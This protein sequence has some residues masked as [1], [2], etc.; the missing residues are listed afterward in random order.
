MTYTATDHDLQCF[1]NLS[2]DLRCIAVVDP[3]ITINER[4]VVESFNLTAEQ[5]FEFRTAEVVGKNIGM[6]MPDP[7][8]GTGIGLI[9]APG[10][11]STFW[12]EFSQ[13]EGMQVAV[14]EE[15]ATQV[16]DIEDSGV[17]FE[18]VQALLSS[19]DA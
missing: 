4:G 9:S 12:V 6:L 17:N 13:V 18:L 5:V 3:I 11:G 16:P 10:E 19:S 14:S 1:F 7:H 15:V 8:Q 2:R